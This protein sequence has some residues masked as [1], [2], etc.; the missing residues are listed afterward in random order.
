LA[1]AKSKGVD[2]NGDRPKMGAME[3]KRQGPL[4]AF[5]DRLDL[6]Q[7]QFARYLT[8]RLGWEISQTEISKWETGA[9]A[10]SRANRE[11]I[12]KA[13]DGRATRG[14]DAW[15]RELRKA[16]TAEVAQ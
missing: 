2:K 11:A 12:S 13:T 8:A 15:I 9:R 6:T 14:Y 10:L 7:E 16:R 3:T 4:R 5:R 1:S